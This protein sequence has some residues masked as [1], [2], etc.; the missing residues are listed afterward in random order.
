[1][2]DSWR[3]ILE[4]AA[5]NLSIDLDQNGP[6]GIRQQPASWPGSR[7]ADPRAFSPRESRD[8]LERELEA[9]P[10]DFAVRPAWPGRRQALQAAPQPSITLA[11]P[12]AKPYKKGPLGEFAPAVIS[13]GIVALTFYAIYNILH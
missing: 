12:A 6:G 7:R 2:P 1:M 5:E 9:R 8:L 13:A 10:E 11:A 3:N 4:R